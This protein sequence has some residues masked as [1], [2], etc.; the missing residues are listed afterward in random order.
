MSTVD[1]KEIAVLTY[2]VKHLTEAVKQL[3]VDIQ[4][5]RALLD[6]KAETTEVN[7]LKE[8]IILLEERGRTSRE[9]CV[10]TCSNLSELEKRISKV[11]METWKIGILL[12][13]TATGG[14]MLALLGQYLLNLFI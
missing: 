9:Q 3:L 12:G 11:E 4:D 1:P 5:H 2:E 13:S 7:T 8:K 10:R 6:R 14:G